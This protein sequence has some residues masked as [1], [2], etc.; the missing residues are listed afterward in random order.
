MI[1][2]IV[3]VILCVFI[4]VFSY[5]KIFLTLRQH[6]AHGRDQFHQAQANQGTITLNIAQYKRRV[7]IAWVQ[8]ALVA[9]YVPFIIMFMSRIF[10]EASE[11]ALDSTLTLFY[12][13]SSL[14]PI[15]YC[16]K[17][18]EVRQEKRNTIKQFCCLSCGD[19]AH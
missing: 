13:N 4:S 12:L 11:I 14:N 19:N 18:R 6:Q 15:L 1:A 8:L 17:I 3:F 10:V 7:F 16:W 2:A 5:T 9:C